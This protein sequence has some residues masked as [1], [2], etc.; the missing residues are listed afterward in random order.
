MQNPTITI[1]LQAGHDGGRAVFESV[2]DEY[3][4]HES[5]FVFGGDVEQSNKY[6]ADRNAALDAAQPPKDEPRQLEAPVKIRVRRKAE[7]IV[8]DALSALDA[9]EASEEVAG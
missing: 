6:I 9:L 5:K 8:A 3:G 1:I 7:P 4:V 2:V